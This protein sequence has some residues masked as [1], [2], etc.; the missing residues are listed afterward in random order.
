[1]IEPMRLKRIGVVGGGLMGSGIAEVAARAGLEALIR[2]PSQ[3]LL[4]RARQRLEKS[5]SAAVEGGKVSAADR[6][7]AASRI[8]YV[9]AIE[10]LAGC[11][12]VI[13]AVPEDVDLKRD[14]FRELDRACE[15]KT[16]LASNTSSIPI[17]ELSAA[18]NRPDRVVG[19]QLLQPG[20]SA[21]CP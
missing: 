21:R 20:S 1:M 10:D 12:V 18:T 8:S 4:D 9:T 7:D 3:E 2:E 11:D 16:V 13:E 6:A 17:A 19:L 5:F 14:I 15:E